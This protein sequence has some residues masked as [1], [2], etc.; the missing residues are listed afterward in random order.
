MCTEDRIPYL[1]YTNWRRGSQA[2]FLI[3]HGF[4]KV[5]IP[6]Y[7]IPLTRKGAIGLR[8]GLHRSLRTYLPERLVDKLLELRGRFYNMRYGTTGPH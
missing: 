4:E 8:L 3:R 6:R 2:E 1:T 5:A 7:W